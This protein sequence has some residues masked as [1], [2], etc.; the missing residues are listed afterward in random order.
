MRGISGYLGG[1]VMAIVPGASTTTRL[2]ELAHA[3]LGH[4][5]GRMPASEFVSRELDAEI[6]AWRMMDRKITP[7]VGIIAFEE[8]R[9]DFGYSN[10][11]ALEL[12]VEGLRRKGIRVTGDSHRDLKN[13]VFGLV[14][15]K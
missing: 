14:D 15:S 11:A 1:G 8:L 9:S 4:E 13:L 6:Y 7:R 5:P 10:T 12:V 3:K 2:H